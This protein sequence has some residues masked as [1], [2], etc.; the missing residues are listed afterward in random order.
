MF[1]KTMQIWEVNHF[2]VAKI[3]PNIIE[4]SVGLRNKNVSYSVYHGKATQE[5]LHK[6]LNLMN[7][8][9]VFSIQE[10]QS[11]FTP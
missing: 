8:K 7:Q 9:K 11:I 2:E 6:I 3:A 5:Q 4:V 10:V 1:D